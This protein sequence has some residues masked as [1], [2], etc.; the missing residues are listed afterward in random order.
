MDITVTIDE[1]VESVGIQT[2]GK[3]LNVTGTDND[4]KGHLMTHLQTAVAN[5]YVRG[6]KINR[7]EADDQA[8]VNVAASYITVS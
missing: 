7:Q 8:A 3:A 1:T 5:L 4:I 6:D 2:I